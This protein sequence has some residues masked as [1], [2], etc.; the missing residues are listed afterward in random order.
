MSLLKETMD[1]KQISYAKP[2]KQGA[3]YYAPMAYNTTQPIHIQTPRM[4]LCSSGEAILDKANP[5]MDVEPMG[6]DF[7][8][9]DLMVA[10]DDRNVKETFKH[11][12]AWF[13][14]DI[15]LELIDDMY[16]R[17]C[18]PVK[19]DGKPQFTYKI[20][21]AKGVV[22]CPLFD[23]HHNRRELKDLPQ[24]SEIILVVHIRGLKFLKQHYYCDM[25]ISQMKVFIPQTDKYAILD[26]CLIKDD[27]E[28]AEVLD[29]AV[30]EEL[31]QKREAIQTQIL[32]SQ[33]EL[34]SKQC[35][36]DALSKH[37]AKLQ[38]DLEDFA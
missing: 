31:K 20:P 19:K 28:P 15:P 25:Y 14:K 13:H 32:E 24:D 2:E 30:V 26:E 3:Y 11:N 22:Q 9:Y 1:C 4:K 29:E 38:Q 8:F 37:I 21:M 27:D 23:Q 5:T 16:K 18:K 6:N 35:E 33:K 12:K 17:S 10:I 34:D 36:I 7:K